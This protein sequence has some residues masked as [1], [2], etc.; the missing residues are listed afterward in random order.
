MKKLTVFLALFTVLAIGITY[1]QG[2]GMMGSGMM[3]SGQEGPQKFSQGTS[4][5]EIFN[6]NCRVCHQNGGNLINPNMPLRGS[7]KLA[8]FDTFLAYIRNPKLPDG[9]QGSM[10]VFS[11]SQISDQQAK[12]LYH[13]ITSEQG[14]DLKRE[15]QAHLYCPYCGLYLGPRRGY[16]MPPHMMGGW[17]CPY[18]GQ[19][20]WPHGGYGM[21]PDMMG[22]RN[23]WRRGY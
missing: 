18:C 21:G 17:Y 2:P 3:G 9:S 11:E 19:Y 8:D 15:G 13:Y 20:M 7:L 12:E 1:A 4:G 6:D 22:P 10:P 5:T 23:F 16:G 14:I